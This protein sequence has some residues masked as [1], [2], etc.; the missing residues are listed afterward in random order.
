MNEE[1]RVAVVGSSGHAKV[2][3]DAI[4]K[5]GKH[6][7]VGLLDRYREVGDELLSYQVLG[8][9]D[10]LPALVKIH[11]SLGVFVA[12]G[13]NFV[14]STVVSKIKEL[15]PNIDFVS[16]VHPAASI[17]SEVEI[18]EGTII[19]AGV[20]VSTASRIGSFCILNTNASLDH[21]SILGDYV[22]LAPNSVTGGDC[23]VGDF[24]AISIG[25][26][27]IH[28]A[29]VGTHS[30]VGAGAL[31]VKPIGDY[32]VAYGSPAREVRTREEGEGY[33]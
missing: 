28:G 11:D 19:L 14:R 20:S 5:E 29:R 18:G 16:V 25:A 27:L 3:I 31:V 8:T 30:V 24:S 13:D 32:L 15:C 7:I 4:E 12:I 22:S 6:R 26:I 33:L 9:E 2:A 1:R 10:D 17:A 21:D 23:L